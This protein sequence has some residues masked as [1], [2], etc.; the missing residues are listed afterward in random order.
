MSCCDRLA[1]GILLLALISPVPAAADHVISL[2]LEAD[3]EDSR[4]VSLLGS[5]AATED[6]WL[7]AA[8]S[9]SD[10]EGRLFDLET[11]Y[12][13]VGVDHFFEPLGMR[14]GGG[15]WGDSDLLDSN[16]LRAAVYWKNDRASLTLNLERR[17][18]DLTLRSPLLPAPRR[19]EFDADGIGFAARFELTDAFS[20][21]AG[22]MRYDYSRDISLEPNVD[23]LRIFALSRLSMVNSLLDERLRAGVEYSFGLRAVD[24]EVASWKTATFGDRV[25]SIGIG[26]LTPLGDASDVEFRL[27]TDDADSFG[28]A[29][30]F[31]VF[32]YFYGD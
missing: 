13:D 21:H 32:F 26:F 11:W 10:S 14:I 29:T 24:L 9:R 30:V 27:T 7:T 8:V 17:A 3:T 19:V 31:S 12:A 1:R 18:F 2:G 20:V 28:R 4:A 15:Y 23:V 22:G 6:T 25:D 16:D 5:V